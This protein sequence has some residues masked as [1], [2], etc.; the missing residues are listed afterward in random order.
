MG[1]A[2]GPSSAPRPARLLAPTPPAFSRSRPGETSRAVPVD[3]GAED[4]IGS[5]PGQG[6]TARSEGGG[7]LA[8]PGD[9]T[10]GGGTSP[11]GTRR[12]DRRL[13]GRW[14]R[15]RDLAVGGETRRAPAR[16]RP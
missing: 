3:R 10:G 11:P 4:G 5:D 16:T 14:R 15:P 6:K 2:P 8:S 13:H 7:V 12:V 1:P 9:G